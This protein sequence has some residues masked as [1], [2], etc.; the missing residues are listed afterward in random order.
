MCFYVIRETTSMSYE[1]IG[2]EFNNMDHS[3][4]LYNIQKMEQLLKND[5]NLNSRVLDIINN[6]KEPV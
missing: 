2:K 4:V 6:I 5:S 3:S 1:A